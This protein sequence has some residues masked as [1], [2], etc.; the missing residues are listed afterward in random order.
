MAKARKQELYS[1][2]NPYPVCSPHIEIASRGETA[3]VVSPDRK[4]LAVGGLSYLSVALDNKLGR[5]QLLQPH[6]SPGMQF[7]GT[8]AHLGAHSELS[9]IGETS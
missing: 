6:R 4:A 5:G 3:I 1:I 8:D 2:L 9:A 7:L